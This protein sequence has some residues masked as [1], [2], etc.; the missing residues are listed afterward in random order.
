MIRL[1]IKKNIDH[2]LLF[3]KNK[4]FLFDF[5]KFDLTKSNLK[6]CIVN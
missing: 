4:S 2:L 5:F 3:L 6:I 1:G